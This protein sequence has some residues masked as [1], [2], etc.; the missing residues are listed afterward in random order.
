MFSLLHSV[1]AYGAQQ[2]TAEVMLWDTC[3]GA[4][5][6]VVP[7]SLWPHGLQPARLLCPWGF[8]GQEYWS[9]LPFPSPGDLPDPG[10]KPGSPALQADSLPSEPTEN[11]IYIY[12]YISIYIY[13]YI[14]IY[15]F[16]RFFPIIGYYKIL[17]ILPVLYRRSLLL[18]LYIA[19]ITISVQI[20]RL[21]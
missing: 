3:E 13:R 17:S 7:D 20:W 5:R 21:T 14:Y 9:G 6:S 8:S 10:I 19:N 1:W 16:F 18:I 15:S 11:P 2:R 12:I 4:R